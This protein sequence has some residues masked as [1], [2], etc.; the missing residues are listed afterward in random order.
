M[1][2]NQVAAVD[3]TVVATVS[4]ATPFDASDVT[5]TNAISNSGPDTAQN[6]VVTDVLPAGLTNVSDISNGGVFNAGTS[7]L[8]WNLSSLASGAAV[9]L[10]F[11]AQI[12]DPSLAQVTNTAT[13]S[14]STLDSNPN[15][16]GSVEVN[17]VALVDLS[18]T[19][20]DAVTS[21]QNGDNDTYTVVVTNNGPD[22]ATDVVASDRLPAGES[23]V[24]NT[25]P[26]GTT[27]NSTNGFWTIGSLPNGGFGHADIDR[28]DQ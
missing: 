19:K 12:S 27:Y 17:P 16:E 4:N 14:T 25:A 26:A 20:T 18:I 1:E 10:T 3:L 24:S 21:V 6:V 22:A 23:F 11:V 7:T 15:P 13:A 2:V 28:E 8:T 5:F 9:S